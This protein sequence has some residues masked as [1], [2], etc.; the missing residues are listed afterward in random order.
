VRQLGTSETS[1]YFYENTERHITER[2]GPVVNTPASYVGGPWF[3]SLP[4]DRLSLGF[5][6][7]PQ[8]LQANTGIVP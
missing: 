1:V 6:G 2:R 7:F 4:E 5:M 8:S 3:K